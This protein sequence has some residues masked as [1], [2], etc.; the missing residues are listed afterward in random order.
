LKDLLAETVD[1]ERVRRQT[2][3][4]LFL[5]ATNVETAKIKIFHGK[6]IS[7]DHV[8]ASTCLP[9]LMHTIEIDGEHYWDGGYAGNP[10]IFPLVYE[11]DTRDILLVHITPAERPGVPTTSSAIMNRMQEISFNIA[12]IREMRVIAF[13]NG[14]IDQGRIGGGKRVLVHLIEAE[15]LIREF[16]WSSR[17][18]GDWNFMMHLHNMGRARAGQWLA[19]NLDHIGVESTVNLQEKYF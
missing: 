3:V 18:N 9:L 19:A 2:T 16:S 8:L 10:A 5:C 4:K 13:I 11:C 7:A 17:L 12:L 14:L 15:D 1:F 6:E